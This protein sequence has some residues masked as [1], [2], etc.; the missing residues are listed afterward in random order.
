MVRTF[1]ILM[2]RALSDTTTMHAALAASGHAGNVPIAL[3]SIC[4][5]SYEPDL[6]GWGCKEGEEDKA[7]RNL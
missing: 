6:Y 5:A 4:L 3:A 2:R 1:D 7:V